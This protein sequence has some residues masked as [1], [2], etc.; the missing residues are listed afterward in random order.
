VPDLP[1]ED[2]EDGLRDILGQMRIA[3]LPQRRRVDEPDVPPR[4]LRQRVARPGGGPHEQVR[5]LEI[6]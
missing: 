3:H 5:I 4:D 2:D 6:H 1:R